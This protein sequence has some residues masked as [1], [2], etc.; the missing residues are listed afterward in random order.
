MTTHL[1]QRFIL[2]LATIAIT[3]CSNKEQKAEQI[4]AQ[5]N[6]IIG[7]Q[8]I[9][10]KYKFTEEPVLVETACRIREMGSNIIKIALNPTEKDKELAS[11]KNA[12]PK[13]LASE[14]PVLKRVLDMDFSYIFMWVT[15]PKVNWGDGMTPEEM[16]CEYSAMKELAE[17]LLTTYNG[18]QK[19][20]YL[21]HWE[22]DWLLLGNYSRTQ[23]HV[24]E[25]RIKGMID[26][27]NVRQRAIED[28]RAQVKSDVKVFHYLELNRANPAL[29]RGYDR[30]ANRVLPYVNVDYVSYS[31]YESTSEEVS[32]ADYEEM[33][34]YLTASLDYI[35]RQMKPN[36]A[37][38]GRRVFIGE[39]GYS[40]SL[41]D[42][43]PQEQAR[44]SVHTIRAALEWG[45][46]FVL[47]WE[48]YDN[49]GI[50]KGFW[51]INHRNEEQPIYKVHKLFY[52]EMKEYVRNYVLQTGEEPSQDSFQQA[53]LTYLSKTCSE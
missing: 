18:T 40:L 48:M 52:Q 25:T 33:K 20:F 4:V 51:M 34:D 50:D 36:S 22:G 42:N 39:Y 37:I 23:E 46:P 24:D 43:S 2:V 49:E 7:T 45:C 31:S 53:A 27:Y 21:G 47:Y 5:Y 28:A 8:T 12:T 11:W 13:T 1:I 30:I 41:V 38:P 10:A 35:E 26:W 16:Q 44:R 17:Y 15:T 32:G 6:Y 9:G 14:C 3:S 19:H 29:Q